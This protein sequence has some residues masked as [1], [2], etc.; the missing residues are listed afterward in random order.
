MNDI[1][2]FTGETALYKMTRHHHS[3]PVGVPPCREN[4]IIPQLPRDQ[5]QKLV[6]KY[7]FGTVHCSSEC[8]QWSTCGYD[9]T[10]NLCCTYWIDNCYWWPY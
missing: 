3:T 2:G 4:G 5:A 7:G 10:L 6:D 8:A 9:P 1:P